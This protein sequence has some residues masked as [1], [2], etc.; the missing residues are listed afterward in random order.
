MQRKIIDL[1]AKREKERDKKRHCS[2]NVT[3]VGEDL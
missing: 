1:F 2:Q 3:H